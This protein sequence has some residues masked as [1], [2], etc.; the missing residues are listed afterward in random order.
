MV[1]SS[2]RQRFERDGYL[3]LP[4]FVP[5]A[6]CAALRARMAELVDG[7]EPGR[8]RGPS[9]RPPGSRTRRTASSSVR[10]P[11]PLLLR[12]R[13]VRRGR[14]ARAARSGRS[15][16][17]ATRCTTSIRCSR[18]SRADRGSRRSRR[19]RPRA[20]AAPVDVHLQAAVH[21]RRGH[22]APGPHVPAPIRRRH[23]LLVRARGRDARQQLHVGRPGSHREPPRER[24][25]PRGRRRSGLDVLDRRHCRA[26][27]VPLEAAE[28]HVH[29]LHGLLPHRSGPNRSPRSRQAYSLHVIDDARATA[30]TTGCSAR[31]IC[32][33]AVSTP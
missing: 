15:T 4:G 23:G 18:V 19:A 2:H 13:G 29:V 28:G 22:R 5:K 7:F 10:R 32:R 17:S 25:R 9:S 16:R 1:A 8:G 14:R 24:F 31:R 20:A 12:G 33:C 27:Q 21:R 30:P 6:E 11:D 3:V 26:R